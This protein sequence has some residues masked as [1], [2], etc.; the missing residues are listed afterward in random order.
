MREENGG[1]GE[2]AEALG[3][4]SA[5]HF[6]GR[7]GK[8]SGRWEHRRRADGEEVRLGK[9]RV[10]R[11]EA[12]TPSVTTS[13]TSLRPLKPNPEDRHGS[14]EQIRQDRERSARLAPYFAARITARF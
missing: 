9:P 4:K 14:V 2:D 7:K 1:P 12:G 10:G 13:I 5:Q 6:P 11:D 8:N 3:T